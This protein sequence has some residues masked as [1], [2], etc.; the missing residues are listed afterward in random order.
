MA[1][2]MVLLLS[3]VQLRIALLHAAYLEESE[4]EYEALLEEA[5][6]LRKAELEGKA[7]VQGS[8]QLP[9]GTLNSSAACKLLG[10]EGGAPG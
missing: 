10:P 1:L 9:P 8:R 7:A 4:R 2:V 5:E 3:L 6:Q